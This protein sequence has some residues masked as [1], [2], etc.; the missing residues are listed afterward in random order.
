MKSS[1]APKDGDFASLIEGKK[2]T[3]TA[4][5]PPDTDEGIDD[6]ASPPGPPP[7]QTMQQVLEGEEPSAEFLEELDALENAP[8]LSDEELAKQALNAPGDDG[9]P[10]TPE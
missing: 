2:K 3:A 9:D 10:G 4:T 6:S 7:R 8:E 5:V 1:D